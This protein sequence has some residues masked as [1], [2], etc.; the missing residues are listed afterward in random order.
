MNWWSCWRERY[1]FLRSS[2]GEWVSR[3]AS[4]ARWRRESVRRRDRRMLLSS[5]NSW[6][7]EANALEEV[8]MVIYF[9]EERAD[10]DEREGWSFL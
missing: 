4:K 6:R 2:I 9:L 10:G 5:L 1:A 7:R 3:A 8:D